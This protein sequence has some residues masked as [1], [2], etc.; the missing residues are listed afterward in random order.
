MSALSEFWCEIRGTFLRRTWDS[1]HEDEIMV[2]AAAISYYA[3]FSFPA[4][5]VLTSTITG[6]VFAQETLTGEFER[7][8]A[9]VIG[10]GAAEQVAQMALSAG[11]GGAGGLIAT[12]I[13]LAVL[14]FSATGVVAQLQSALDRV[15]DVEPDPHS[16]AVKT[17]LQQR[18]LS[19]FLIVGIAVTGLVFVTTSSLVSSGSAFVSGLLPAGLSWVAAQAI[20]VGVNLVLLTVLFMIVYKVLPDARV[21]WGVVWGGALTTA[22]LFDLG[23]WG[24]SLYFGRTDLAGSYGAAGSLALLMAWVYYSSIVMLLGAELTREWARGRGDRV[25]A[26]PGAIRV[27]WRRQV[28]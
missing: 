14:I 3:V 22:L 17:L 19:F 5:L 8:L 12:L 4:L 20:G 23:Q 11:R 26:A 25:R 6:I 9:S 21:S 7:Q 15:W 1:F 18:V 28:L 16:N 2:R 27:I 10:T 24:L 13:G